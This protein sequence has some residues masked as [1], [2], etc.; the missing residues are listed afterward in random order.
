M[1]L[2]YLPFASPS[3][4]VVMTAAAV[5][6]TPNRIVVNTYEK[7]QLKP[8]YLKIN[9]QHTVPTLVD[10]G[11]SVWESRAIMV[12][13]AEK[14]GK[15]DSL[16]P[17]DPQKQAVVN[18]RL[19][20]DLGVLTQA[21]GEYYYPIFRDEAPAD[22]EK[23]KK[24][25]AAFEFLNTFLE[26]EKYVAGDHFTVA[27]IAILVTVTTYLAVN[28]KIDSYPNVLKWYNSV[29]KEAPGWEENV[30]AAK[31]YTKRLEAAQKK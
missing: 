17:K 18:Q 31:E 3:R 19:H 30:E 4:A 12:Y 26:G 11:F 2:Y 5:G 27:D 10:N 22:P 16:F 20:F 25:E 7:E 28:F 8:E 9:P 6:V 29:Q 14:Y 24:V 15:D 13:L 21:F 1:D 23:F